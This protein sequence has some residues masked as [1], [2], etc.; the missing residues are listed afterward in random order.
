LNSGFPYDGELRGGSQISAGREDCA[1]GRAVLLTLSK[2]LEIELSHFD[3][4]NATPKGDYLRHVGEIGIGGVPTVLEV[5]FM[6]L[7]MSHG[8]IL[9]P[10]SIWMNLFDPVRYQVH[11][12]KVEDSI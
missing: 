8:R 4:E 2:S 5:C 11:L 1:G 7:F 10:G 6:C 9:L 12:W 3:R